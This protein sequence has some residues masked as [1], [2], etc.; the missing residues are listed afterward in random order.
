MATSSKI[1]LLDAS[2]PVIEQI[3]FFHDHTLIILTIITAL[4]GYSITRIIINNFTN[5]TLL[6]GQDIEIL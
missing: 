6:E 1:L 3:I 2:S 4:V 5:R